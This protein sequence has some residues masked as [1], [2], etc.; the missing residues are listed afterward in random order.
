MATD[1]YHLDRII[2][3]AHLSIEDDQKTRYI[4][5]LGDILDYINILN[6]ADLASV[7]PSA[8]ALTESPSLRKDEISSASNLSFIDNAPVWEAGSF[9]VP[10]ILE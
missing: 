6:K 2:Q 5:Q 4:S 3:L 9:K 8:Y 10:K 1:P 7:E